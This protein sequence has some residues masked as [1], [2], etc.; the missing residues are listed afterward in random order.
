AVDWLFE[1]IIDPAICC[2]ECEQ[3]VFAECQAL[4]KHP[5]DARLPTFSFRSDEGLQHLSV[6]DFEDTLL[7]AGKNA[8]V[9]DVRE[10]EEFH[11]GHLC[12][13]QLLPLRE[14]IA[15]A[16]SLPKGR[17]IF[18]VCRSGRRSTRA[19]HW[20]LDLGFEDVY[21]I[22]GGILSWKARGRPLEVD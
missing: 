14:I 1:A 21:N 13:S 6:R 5:Y 12:R 7:R 20:L 22:K 16:P 15:E 18:L 19:M 2:Y 9:I 17:P 10:P 8:L 3:R 4:D 11:A